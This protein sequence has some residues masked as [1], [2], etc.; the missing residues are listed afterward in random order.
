LERKFRR[1]EARKGESYQ[2]ILYENLLP[3]IQEIIRELYLQKK[4]KANSTGEEV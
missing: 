4:K 1:V 3:E 2:K